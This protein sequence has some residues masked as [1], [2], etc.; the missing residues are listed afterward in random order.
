MRQIW[1]PWNEWESYRAGFYDGHTDLSPDQARAAYAEFLRDTGRFEAA[2]ER[3]LAEW[4]VSCEHFL[5]NERIN[6]I[7]WLGQA[8]MCIATGVPSIY[9]SGFSAMSAED[10]DRANAVAAKWLQ[11]WIDR[12]ETEDRA[13]HQDVEDER[14]PGGHPGRGADGPNGSVLGPFVPSHLSGDPEERRA[15]TVAWVHAEKVSGVH[16]DQAAGNRTEET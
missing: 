1:H 16:G 6:R 10:R 13:V 11:T 8:A 2:L 14:L 15:A 9:K 7:A 4:P 3:V 5:S 12:H